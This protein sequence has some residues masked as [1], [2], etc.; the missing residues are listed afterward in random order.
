MKLG[1]NGFMLVEVVVVSAVIATVLVTMFIAINRVSSAYSTRDSYNSVDALYLAMAVNDI[2]R[3]NN[4]LSDLVCNNSNAN[5]IT[6][7]NP[8]SNFENLK[9]AYNSIGSIN[10]YYSPYDSGKVLF[11]KNYN[12][13]VTF[14]GF[15][16]YISNKLDY[17]NTNYNYLI[18]AELC[19]TEDDCYYYALKLKYDTSKCG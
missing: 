7:S 13:K 2:L 6:D 19:K 1:R 17:S 10:L 18:I 3:E 8:D 16:D 9:G 4:D 12:N 11:L 14:D 5:E 15:I